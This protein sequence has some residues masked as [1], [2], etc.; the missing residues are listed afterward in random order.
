MQKADSLATSAPL[1]PCDCGGRRGRRLPEK[2]T[3]KTETNVTMPTVFALIWESEFAGDVPRPQIIRAFLSEEEAAAH[4]D[5]G[6]E[7]YDGAS[8]RSKGRVWI[9]KLE[10]DERI[11]GLARRGATFGIT[12][13][14]QAGSWWPDGAPAAM[15]ERRQ[16]WTWT[17]EQMRYLLALYAARN[18]GDWDQIAGR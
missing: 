7:T 2:V 14:W 17:T 10:P 13:D 4:P 5:A 6:R 16:A 8:A 11:L 3:M 18:P 9:R 15:D 1:P 12:K